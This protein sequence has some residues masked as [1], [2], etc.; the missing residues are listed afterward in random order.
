M[1]VEH[2]L[3]LPGSANNTY[4]SILVLFVFTRLILEK[5]KPRKI[6]KLFDS[7]S[8][9]SSTPSYTTT[10]LEIRCSILPG[11]VMSSGFIPRM[12]AHTSVFLHFPAFGIWSLSIVNPPMSLYVRALCQQLQYVGFTDFT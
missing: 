10:S 6:A 11:L 4:I 7:I 2:P 3:A 1:F 12:L 8:S 9:N 5:Y